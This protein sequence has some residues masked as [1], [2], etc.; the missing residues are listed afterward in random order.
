MQSGSKPDKAVKNSS[1]KDIWSV[2]G[3]TKFW[4]GAVEIT[5]SLPA[6]GLCSL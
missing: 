6:S 3:D 2:Q 1:V 5:R 4:K